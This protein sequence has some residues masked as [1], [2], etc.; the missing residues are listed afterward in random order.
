MKIEALMGYV[1]IVTYIAEGGY[2]I[3]ED[4]EVLDAIVDCCVN[5]LHFSD[6]EL[7]EA[8][9]TFRAIQKLCHY[10]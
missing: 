7:D 9:V 3:H 8:L 2:N 5:R 6:E 4:D 1:G 10:E